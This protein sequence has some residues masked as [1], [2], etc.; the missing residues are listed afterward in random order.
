MFLYQ[1]PTFAITD[2]KLYDPVVTLSTQD[3]VKL[4]R[5][6]KS[7]FKR[8]INWNKYRSKVTIQ[9]QNQ[10]LDYLN[11]PGFQGVT[12]LFVSSFEDNAHRTSQE[13]VSSIRSVFVWVAKRN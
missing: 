13:E 12:R 8:T 3:N 7:G 5:Q 11:D 2:T 9:I 1:V 10:Y 6:L 4:L